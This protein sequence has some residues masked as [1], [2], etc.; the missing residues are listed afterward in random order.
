MS[1]ED[2]NDVTKALAA[3]GAPSIRYHSFGQ[4]QV[5]PSSVV[6]P[7]REPV[8][9]LPLQTLSPSPLPAPS[10]E[11][12]PAAAIGAHAAPDA[13]RARFPPHDRSGDNPGPA[14]AAPA[15]PAQRSPSCVRHAECSACP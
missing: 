2:A 3:F 5:K 15:P 6:M 14:G 10:D 9:P 4:G 7:R 11:N 8:P 13:A 1:T 12:R